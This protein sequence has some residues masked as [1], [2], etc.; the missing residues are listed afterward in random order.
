MAMIPDRSDL[1]VLKPF[2]MQGAP[3]D[4]MYHVRWL[5]GIPLRWVVLLLLMLHEGV[6]VVWTALNHCSN[7]GCFAR[8]GNG[9][10]YWL[11]AGS[12]AHSRPQI[13]LLLACLVFCFLRH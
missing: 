12:C 10:R 7:G 13:A 3:Y 5:A 8:A 2:R 4:A 1:A 6:V 9:H 11:F